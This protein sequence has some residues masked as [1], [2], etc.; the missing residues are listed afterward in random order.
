MRAVEREHEPDAEALQIW[1]NAKPVVGTIVAE[2]LERRGIPLAPPPSLRSC[3]VMHLNRYDMPAM[4]AGVQR[5]DGQVVAVQTTI[6]TPKGMQAAVSVPKITSGALGA[7]AVRFAA[8]AEVMGIAEGV[9][10]ALSAQT[11]AEIPVWAS[12]GCQRLHRVD[13]PEIVQEVHI[14]GDNDASGRAAAQRASEVHMALGRRVVLRF[15][16]DGLKD[17]NDL[18]NADADESLRDL[19]PDQVKGR[20]AA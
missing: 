2:Y 7:G 15:P 4:V 12:L 17:F 6:L 18:L 16:P 5:P 8:A 14:F 3:R 20:V 11:M 1:R 9:E 10:T 19:R 13:L